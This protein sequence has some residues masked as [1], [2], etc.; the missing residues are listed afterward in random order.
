MKTAFASWRGR[1]LTVGWIVCFIVGTRAALGQHKATHTRLENVDYRTTAGEGGGE[2][3]EQGRGRVERARRSAAMARVEAEVPGIQVDFD[4][5]TGAPKH[6]RVPGGF[7]SSA[8]AAPGGGAEVGAG[9]GRPGN[10]D[11]NRNGN[12]NGN[13][14][15]RIGAL[16]A[17]VRT[18]AFLDRH[19]ELFGHGGAVLTNGNARVRR[20]AFAPRSGMRTM[21]WEQELD[22]LPVVDAVLVSH[23]TA[24]G[25]LVSLSSQFVADPAR[26][27]GDPPG[28]RARRAAAPPITL[29]QAVVLAARELGDELAEATVNRLPATA[30]EVN[31]AANGAARRR[32][33]QRLTAGKL[34]G[35]VHGQLAWLPIAPDRLRLC[36]EL[37]LTGRTHPEMFS[38]WVD[39]GTGKVW[40]RRSLTAYE[41]APPAS[42]RV[43][44]SDS[45]T[46]FSPGHPFPLST[47]PAE[48]S[49][50]LVVTNALSLEA[51]P[52][53][54]LPPGSGETTG[55]NVDAHTDLNDDDRPDLPRPQ[56]GPGRVFDFPMDLT[57]PP[58]TYAAA[59]VVQ[60]FYWCNWMHDQLYELGF[61]EAAGNFQVNNFERGGEGDDPVQADAQDGGGV[62]NANMSTPPDGISPRMQMYVFTGP[63]PDRDGTLDAEVVLHEYTHGLSNR[64]VGGG[65]GI[66]RLQS[67][68]MGEG[69]SDFYAL[70][71]LSEPGDDPDAAYAAGGYASYQL[72]GLEENYYYGIRR[73]PY[74]TDLAKNPLTFKDIDPTQAVAHD[75]VPR[76]PLDSFFVAAFASEV[77]NQGEV[78]CSML[79]EARARLIRK[80][81]FAVGNRL[82]LQLVTDGMNLS[83]PN[84]NFVQARDAILLADRVNNAGSN[85]ND[86][87]L[88]FAK[89]GLGASA[90]SPASSTTTGVRESFDPPDAL[91]VRPLT[92]WATA[93]R[94]PEPFETTAQTFTLSN[95]GPNTL[96][97]V[98]LVPSG[99][100]KVSPTAGSLGPRAVQS[101]TIALD[102]A[103]LG[104]PPGVHVETVVF[105]N[106]VTRVAQPRRVTARISA[107]DYL[108]EVFSAGDFDLDFQMLTFT[109]DESAG[110][111]AVCRRPVSQFAT[112][113]AGGIALTLG[114]DQARAITLTNGAEVALFGRR[115]N[116]F[117]VGSNGYL[118]FD[119]DSNYFATASTH[120]SQARVSALFTDL[121]P[122]LGG[123]VTWKQLSNRVAV[124]FQNVQEQFPSAT[125]SFQV[126]WFYD[127]RIRVAYLRVDSVDPVVGLSAGAGLPANFAETDFGS[128][129]DCAVP[130]FQLVLPATPTEGASGLTGSIR[131][132][133]AFDTNVTVLLSSSDPTELVVPGQV[134]IPAGETAVEFAVQA[135]D[136]ARLDGSQFVLVSASATGFR[137]ASSLVEVY[138]N[139]STSL[140]LLL[141]SATMEGAGSVTGRVELGQAPARPVVVR[142]VSLN[143]NELRVPL[144]VLVPAG[145]SGVDWLA[146]VLDDS[147]LDGSQTFT[148]RAQVAAW[149]AAET[150]IVVHDNESTNLLVD[151]PSRLRE[152]QGVSKGAG[153][154]RLSGTL[155]YDLTI[156]LETSEAGEIQV[157][158]EVVVRK[159]EVEAAFDLTVMDDVVVDG[160]RAAIVTASA[161]GFGAGTDR[162]V[163]LDNETPYPAARP[164]PADRA[165]NVAATV[166]LAWGGGEVDELLVNGGFE[167]GTLRGWTTV[168]GS[169]G[170]FA[171]YTATNGPISGDGRVAPLEGDFYLTVQQFGPGRHELYQTFTIP[172]AE[173]GQAELNWGDRVQNQ[174]SDF[175]SQQEYRVELRSTN[176]LVLAV[177]HQ[178]APGDPVDGPWV[179]RRLDL[180]AYAGQT[181]RLAFV[182]N[183]TRAP[184]TVRLDEVSVSVRKPGTTEFEVFF[185]RNPT[186]GVAER[187][188]TTTA[189]GWDL[190]ELAPATTYYWQ[191]NARTL[192]QAPG[193]IWQFT[194]VGV[195]RF[196]WEPVPSPQRSGVPFPVRLTARDARGV[197]VS[198]FNGAVQLSAAAGVTRRLLFGDDFE[199]GNL[200]GWTANS[201]YESSS[202]ISN[203]AAEGGR[204]LTVVGGRQSHRDG[205]SHALPNLKPDR[206][207]FHVRP[208][209]VD[210]LGGYL[211]VGTSTNLDDIAVYFYFAPDGMGVYEDEGGGHAVPYQPGRWY[212]V[213]L[214]LSW[215][216]RTVDYWV[217]GVLRRAGI[218]FRRPA[219]PYLSRIDLYNYDFTQTWWD[220]I[221]LLEENQTVP[222]ALTPGTSGA[223][224][225]GRWEGEVTLATSSAQATLHAADEFGHRGQ[226]DPFAVVTDD[227]LMIRFRHEPATLSLES[228]V[229]MSVEVFNPGPSSASGLI[230]T[231][232]VP[233]G[234]VVESV[235]ASS[236]ECSLVAGR[237]VCDLGTLGAN[238]TFVLT[239]NLTFAGYGRQTNAVILRETGRGGGPDRVQ[240][241]SEVLMVAP[242]TLRA[243]EVRVVEG[244][245]GR[246]EARF[247]LELSA[248]QRLPVTV[249]FVTSNLTAVAGSDFIPADGLV[250]FAPG[251]TRQTV[252]VPVL[253]DSVRE[254][255]EVFMLYLRSAENAVVGTAQVYGFILD[256]DQTEVASLPWVEGWE[257]GVRNYWITGGTGAFRSAV[258]RSNEPH[259]GVFHLVMDNAQDDGIPARIEQTLTVDLAGAVNPVL[260]F[261]AMGSFYDS[262]DV[263]PPSPFLAGADFDGVAVSADGLHWYE[264]QTLRS[265]DTE[266]AEFVVPLNPVMAKHGLSYNGRFRIR[267]NRV[268]SY[269]FPFSGV[270]IDDLSITADSRGIVAGAL[271]V[272]AESCA[273]ANQ[274]IDAGETVTAMFWLTNASARPVG[275]ITATLLAGGNVASPGPSQVYT[276]LNPGGPGVAR[277]FTFQADGQCGEFVIANLELQED[278]VPAGKVQF[279]TMLGRR[280]SGSYVLHQSTP[281]QIPSNGPATPFP[282]TIVVAGTT[283]AIS[284]VVVTLHE[285]SHPLPDQVDVMLRGPGGQT[286]TL[287]SDT[288]GLNPV[289][290]ATLVFDGASTNRL[291]DNGPIVA[292]TYSPTNHGSPDAYPL[293]A[294]APPYGASLDLFKGTS[295]E[296]TWELFVLDDTLR[297]GG[298][299]GGWTLAIE[300]EAF[301]CC[302]A[303]PVADVSLAMTVSPPLVVPGENV[304]YEGTI[305]NRGPHP[306]LNVVFS[307]APPPGAAFVGAT[308]SVGVCTIE[309][310]R[311]VCALGVMESNATAQVSLDLR[312]GDPGALNNLASV[313]SANRDSVPSNNLARV[314]SGVVSPFVSIQDATATESSVGTVFA[315]FVVTTIPSA[316]TALVYFATVDQSAIAGVD[317]QPTNG[318]ITFLPGETSKAIDVRVLDDALDEPAETFGLTLY[319]AVHLTIGK[320]L[321][322][323]TV[324]DNDAV[325]SLSIADASVLEGN[326]GLAPAHFRLQ[327]SA[328][329]G[330]RVA[331][332]FATANGTANAASDYVATNGT[333]V[334]VPGETSRLLPVFVRGDRL[335]EAAET[336]TL[337]LTSPIG[338]ALGDAQGLATILN[339]DTLPSFTV[340]AGPVLAESCAAPNGVIDPDETVT[341][342]F[343]FRNSATGTARAS[344]LVATLLP[345]GG[346]LAPGA[347]QVVGNIGPGASGAGDFNLKAGVLCGGTLD[348]RFALRDGD[349]ELGTSTVAIVVGTPVQVLAENFDAVTAP[350]LPLGWTTVRAGNTTAWRTT[351]SPSDTPPNAVTAP[352]PSTRSTNDLISPVVSIQTAAA[353]LAFR[354]S[355]NTESNFD[356]G[357]LEISL[358]GAPYLELTDA[359]GRF[360][361]GGY[362]GTISFSQPAW[363][364]LSTGFQSVIAALPPS[365][366]GHEVRFRWRFTSDSSAGG[367]GWFLDTVTVTDG[368]ACCALPAPIFTSILRERASV[369]LHW[370]TIQDRRYRVQ[371]KA[372]LDEVEWVDRSDNLTFDGDEGTWTDEG[373]V[374]GERYY[375]VVLW[376]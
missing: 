197:V 272:T 179:R 182:L 320:S 189:L 102:N 57:Q 137:A 329:S 61:D 375:R 332:N 170:Y 361:S 83:P 262:P 270:A 23:V 132:P 14:P 336:F 181:V 366:E 145:A 351:T 159:G 215:T 62:N 75:G 86:L 310:G 123:S 152:G 253:G 203:T 72:S 362:N 113:P 147:R 315:R 104:L 158:S 360:L 318:W 244:N 311:V 28:E 35:E 7:L 359:G 224:V 299:L 191:V 41:A 245:Q 301:D 337:N 129:A 368:F 229:A 251:T 80:H 121:N 81:G 128:S 330:Q 263:P 79:W 59:S 109:P 115:T 90:T 54:W 258:T 116:V 10:R 34:P 178:T 66:F 154:V 349:L 70:A 76:S 202:V 88:A 47:Q 94:I 5:V 31:A 207:S 155:D 264:V 12:G 149:P 49:R 289:Q 92:D 344:N 218:P 17:N 65:V 300:T 106:T 283:G 341:A 186:P 127:G 133:V 281:I 96:T 69:W 119:A 135:V 16:E 227:Q 144:S 150:T 271:E 212:H 185:G 125:N 372:S 285:F 141:P 165:T 105:S 209:R 255:D 280:L 108:T 364:G 238:S 167:D 234:A 295:A 254:A 30:A 153:T 29:E 74:C 13:G 279:R 302:G 291:S 71:L 64:R 225:E 173:A 223:F 73:Y 348:V 60:L 27:A 282:S 261:W 277:P 175:S 199:D 367:V 183:P 309:A 97:W 22:G 213:E 343:F 260:R 250:V 164:S 20:E 326:N 55:N 124:T 45:P 314:V 290:G 312:V 353:R 177:A 338:V 370:T 239:A 151:V 156:G 200:D 188:G 369:T 26:A 297:D 327:L 67:A 130:G 160:N 15:A 169:Y 230:L 221:E 146:S 58:S 246:T 335:N 217:D 352:N 87:W 46:P 100:L 98:A 4:P 195:D 138:D 323:A 292:G 278:G 196:S 190:P 50:V 208:L 172:S 25:D 284:K 143:T 354:H 204:S 303:E 77:H 118:T 274:A 122:G 340:Q 317:Y 322:V 136:D 273:P 214:R 305:L 48:R 376:P 168:P 232:T 235:T 11:G 148:V 174:D 219:V 268:S 296:G 63:S 142:L 363:T 9:V 345:L 333:V 180:S 32:P 308:S 287:L 44:T 316:R 1:V 36:W 103:S 161:P 358:D 24:A 166:D 187:L 53:G 237:I 192:G 243:Q 241:E 3:E 2:G 210:A 355:F 201:D 342:R 350:A 222:L 313:Q 346:V 298:S 206:I 18:R 307:N 256:D 373:P 304:R 157:P 267:F 101:V 126:E 269:A 293:P 21:V 371:S 242:P 114:D 163:V 8:P 162:V 51:S 82:I 68:G 95:S 328:A 140:R 286:V 171:V 231:N 252:I 374:V 37:V 365:A 131:L 211:T 93:R 198:N 233:T 110:G 216:E 52:A 91:A 205:L 84:P 228:P 288:G 324:T 339:D 306:A 266:Y 134:V 139:E 265:L 6:V 321:A 40:M 259:A 193:P 19:R 184:L 117:F 319:N 275:V 294:P 107:G 111:Y 194:T 347:A 99:W 257:R 42:Y 120:F 356:G 247:E 56:A 85:V 220:G 357:V 236:G 248:P 78:W 334:I 276:G 331:V 249:R 89:R 112:D 33:R 176:D 38:V 39:A 226:S 43:Y 240:S 325:P